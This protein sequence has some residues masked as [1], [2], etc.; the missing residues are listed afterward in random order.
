MLLFVL[1]VLPCIGFAT[2]GFAVARP[3]RTETGVLPYSNAPKPTAHAV[4][5]RGIT[6]NCGYVN[7]NARR[8]ILKQECWL[9]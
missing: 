5:A 9:W 1:A 2:A 8:Y 7:G 4:L 6:K 3:A